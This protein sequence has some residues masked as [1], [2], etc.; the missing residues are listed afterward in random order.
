MDV[1]TVKTTPVAPKQALKHVEPVKSNAAQNNT[2][3]PKPEAPKPSP[4]VNTQ[5][6]QTG[7][8]LNAVA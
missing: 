1:S 8:L 7:R 4:M 2:H 6:H 3:A 5:G